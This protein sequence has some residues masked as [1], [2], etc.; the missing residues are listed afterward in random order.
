MRVSVSD[1][2]N[3]VIFSMHNAGLTNFFLI[4]LYHG[5]F[6][7]HHSIYG[8]ATVATDRPVRILLRFNSLHCTYTSRDAYSTIVR[9]VARPVGRTGWIQLYATSLPLSSEYYEES[10]HGL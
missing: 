5:L 3:E 4:V 6:E 7:I 8:S 1:G 9:L 10:K 2:S